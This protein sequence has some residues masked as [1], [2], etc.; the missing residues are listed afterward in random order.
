MYRTRRNLI[1]L[2]AVFFSLFIN[3]QTLAEEVLN[4]GSSIN[5][6]GFIFDIQKVDP[7][8]L[9]KD[10]EKLREV[11]IQRQHELEHL[12][13]NK[14]LNV[15]DAIVT[16]IIPGGLFYAGYRKQE[17]EQAKSDLLAVTT[18]IM[19]LSND[20]LALQGQGTT[21]PLILAQLP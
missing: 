2:Y 3:K 18:E 17:L 16:I 4:S 14:K 11:Y 9:T 5:Q 1:L 8:L 15:G 10:L 21:H 13:E 7:V 19:E 6:G 20:L 12:V